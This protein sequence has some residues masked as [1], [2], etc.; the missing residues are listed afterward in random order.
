MSK[1]ENNKIIVTLLITV[2]VIV[3][4][5][6]FIYKAGGGEGKYQRCINIEGYAEHEVIADIA[7]WS[8]YFE[9][10]GDKYA[11]LSKMVEDDKPKVLK[12]LLQHGVK[13][14]DIEF[15]N[16]IKEDYSKLEK[17][18]GVRRYKVG[19]CA[20]IKTDA[21]DIVTNLKNSIFELCEDNVSVVRDELVLK[22]SKQEEL[23]R[24]VCKKAVKNA[25][26]KALD[27]TKFMGLKLG[28]II[29]IGNARVNMFAPY[30]S[31]DAAYVNVRSHPE[32]TAAKNMKNK[33]IQAHI[34]LKI[35][36]K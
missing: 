4:C 15:Y 12:F 21:V 29:Q 16:Y 10:C 7:E 19:C 25:M 34:D 28:K 22:Y 24:V 36:I 13:S 17:Y 2:L 20:K 3:A 9:R 18:D 33:K 1:A 31:F 5:I 14:E 11:D 6:A 30:A 27:I 23:E 26:D 35:G 8:I 32:N